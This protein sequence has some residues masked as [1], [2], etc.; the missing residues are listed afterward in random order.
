MACDLKGKN[1][2]K[3]PPIPDLPIPELALLPKEAFYSE[4]RP[5]PFKES[6]GRISGEMIMAY[7]PGIPIICPGEII[8]HD[9][10][11]EVLLLKE[12]GSLIQGMEDRELNYV[13]VIK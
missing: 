8:T 1:K 5:H 11:D 10:I 2:I 13:N 6:Y 12:A 3:L 4:K 7:P 9:I